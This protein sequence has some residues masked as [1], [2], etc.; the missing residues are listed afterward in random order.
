MNKKIMVAVEQAFI[1]RFGPWAG[2]AHN[3][4]FISELASQR[5]RLPA[6]LQPGAK[7][8]PKPGLKAFQLD[9][10][11]GIDDQA[12]LKLRS[13]GPSDSTGT[14]STN[15]KKRRI[16]GGVSKTAK[17]KAW[18][19]A[20]AAEGSVKDGDGAAVKDPI[21]HGGGLHPPDEKASQR[22]KRTKSKPRATRSSAAQ[23][24]KIEQTK[25]LGSVDVS[26]VA[27]AAVDQA[28]EDGAKAAQV[29]T[30]RKR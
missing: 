8:K 1:E 14:A 2:W 5:D 29:L 3:T 22:G 13:L 27:V 30:K 18:D 21:S 10:P 7:V 12:A 20:A 4:L 24:G 16:S 6:H 23:P 17:G 25:A 19:Q 28:I 15:S 11:E 9:R 26:A